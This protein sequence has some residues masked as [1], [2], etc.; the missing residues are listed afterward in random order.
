MRHGS[1]ENC[2]S[3]WPW[4]MALAAVLCFAAP[5]P[6]VALEDCGT[7]LSPEDVVQARSLEADGAYVL[8]RGLGGA[9]YVPLTFHV[10]RTSAG[11]GGLGEDR[12]E[13]A[14]LDAN[15]LF[16]GSGIRFCRPQDTRYIDSD[17][18]YFDID[19]TA[20]INALRTTDVVADTIN[21]YF[22]ENLANENGPIGGMSSFTYSPVQ[23][24]VMINGITATPTNHSSFPHELGHYFDLFHTH[25]T[26]FGLE[27]VDGSNCPDA[28]DLL[29][30]T[31]A[32]PQLGSGNVTGDCQY[33]GTERGPCHGDAAYAPDPTNLLSYAWPHC[34]VSLTWQ[35]N[36]K[37]RATLENL[38]PELVN[39]TSPCALGIPTLDEWGIS[40]MLLLVLGAGTLVLRR[41]FD[42]G[43]RRTP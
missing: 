26:A 6:T 4:C 13:Q 34:R 36:E 24:I 37:A 15:E 27:C 17:A 8:P 19:T 42:R 3:S 38:R 31:P 28:G 9:V 18:F 25:E 23:G 21:L 40:V 10:V 41:V 29:C 5:A 14:L 20:E 2:S 35:Q 11:T 30:D 12:I 1:P 39:H 22:T 33:T 32:D 43:V 16:V 7:R